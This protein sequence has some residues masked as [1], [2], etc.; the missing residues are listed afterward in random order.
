MNALRVVIADDHDLFRDGLV[1]I[2][3][4]AENLSVV[5]EAATGDDAVAMT[6]SLLP[7]V[8][9]LDV[10]MPGIP[11]LSTV[12]RLSLEAPLT[13]IVVVTMHRDRVLAGQLMAA[14]AAAFISKAAS[15]AD[16]MT[17]L[18]Q[19]RSAPLRSEGPVR[20]H[21]ASTRLSARE[22]EV[23]RLI[24]A[25]HTN[26]LIGERLSIAVGTVKRHNSHIFA[27]LGARSRTDAVRRA[28]TLGELPT[29]L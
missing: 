9:L 18:G 17:A 28:R 6:L 10:E 19:T 12:T 1:R 26:A 11:V 5:G 4:G 2:L 21:S 15:A 14:G 22:R 16:L 7:D 3:S 25:G 23:L 27:K 13:R 29:H 24:A 20:R 8:L